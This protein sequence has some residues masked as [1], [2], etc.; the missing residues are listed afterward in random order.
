[1]ALV[2]VLCLLIDFFCRKITVTNT[3]HAKFEVQAVLLFLMAKHYS[4]AAT[5]REVY[6]F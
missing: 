6:T 4:A 3:K 1:M 5:H 2:K